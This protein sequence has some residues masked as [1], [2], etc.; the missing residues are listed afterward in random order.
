MG[1]LHLIFVLWNFRTLRRLYGRVNDAS[2]G[3]MDQ[4]W[5]QQ[6]FTRRIDV[7]LGPAVFTKLAML[8][9]LAVVNPDR[10]PV[11]LLG[12]EQIAKLVRAL[13]D[14]GSASVY[15]VFCKSTGYN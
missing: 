9:N 6:S 12:D 2:P 15:R 3:V 13:N 5:Q 7:A 14:R 10:L 1:L 11:H 8:M 4:L